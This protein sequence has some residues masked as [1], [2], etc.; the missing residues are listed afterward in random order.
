MRR[1]EGEGK[2]EGMR[3]R[4]KGGMREGGNERRRET[5]IKEQR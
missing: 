2:K 1:R 3:R 4:E 5:E